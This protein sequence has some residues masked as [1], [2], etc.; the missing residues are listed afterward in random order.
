MSGLGQGERGRGQLKRSSHGVVQKK[1][2]IRLRLGLGSFAN[3]W[4]V[5][6]LE[7]SK[8]I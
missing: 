1:M 8:I 2:F 4:D 5:E 6:A 3:R 7:T